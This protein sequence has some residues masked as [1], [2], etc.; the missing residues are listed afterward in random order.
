MTKAYDA[1]WRQ[2]D[3][4]ISKLNIVIS[5]GNMLNLITNFLNNRTFQVKVFNQHSKR[6]V[7]GNG[8]PQSSA[9]SI[10]LFLVAINKINK[11][12]DFS[13]KSNIFADD[14]NF[15]CRSKNIKTIKF[16][17]LETIIKLENWLAKMV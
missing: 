5:S 16:Y 14:V 8:V 9:L 6:F 13:I 3:Y 17:L 11:I 2:Y 7:Q 12:W 4:I 1:T 10:T 15:L